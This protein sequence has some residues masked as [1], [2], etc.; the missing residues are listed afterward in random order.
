MA[1]GNPNPRLTAAFIA[2]QF[3]PVSELPNEKLAKQSLAVKV[4]ESVDALVRQLPQKTR[5][6]WL[7]RIICEAARMELSDER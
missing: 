2:A 6:E 1:K 5:I 4:P 7:R 3:Q